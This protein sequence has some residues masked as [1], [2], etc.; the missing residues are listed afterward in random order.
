MLGQ[1]GWGGGWGLWELQMTN[2]LSLLYLSFFSS[3][4]PPLPLRL[5]TRGT[6]GLE[7]V[8]GHLGGKWQKLALS[9]G[10]R[11]PS[12]REEW[13]GARGLELPA[14]PQSHQDSPGGKVADF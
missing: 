4:D 11:E 14:A 12:P 1:L 5:L 6:G 2:L 10:T 7:E 8:G 9:W 3:G 13:V